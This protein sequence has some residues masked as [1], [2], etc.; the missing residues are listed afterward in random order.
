MDVNIKQCDAILNVPT[1][2]ELSGL[3]VS[4]N[5]NATQTVV[6]PN[7]TSYHLATLIITLGT[8]DTLAIQGRMADGSTVGLLTAIGPAGTR[9]VLN[10]TNLVPANN[11]LYILDRFDIYDMLFVYTQSTGPLSVQGRLGAA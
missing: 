11:G 10:T 8:L 5:V 4:I 7:L 2:P 1:Y 3:N 6:I 9:V